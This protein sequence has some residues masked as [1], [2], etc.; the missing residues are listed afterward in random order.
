MA[1]AKDAINAKDILAFID[2]NSI[3]V[4]PKGDII[5]VESEI[6]RL[7]EQKPYLFGTNQSNKGG[8]QHNDDKQKGNSS[9]GGMNA[10][11]RRAA[12]II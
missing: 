7:K 10:L 3:K 2:R 6:A 8:M 9:S 1:H 12:G 5:G 11:L 4:S